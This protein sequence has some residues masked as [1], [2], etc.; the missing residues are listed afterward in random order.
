MCLTTVAGV[1]AGGILVTQL[2]YPQRNQRRNCTGSREQGPLVERPIMSH[3]P[4]LPEAERIQDASNPSPGPPGNSVCA[5][6]PM[7]QFLMGKTK[8][9][10]ITFK[11]VV[12]LGTIGVNIVNAL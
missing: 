1:V 2:M 7:P 6:L 4:F 12:T 9:V 8:I 10:I 11:N 5:S 3:V